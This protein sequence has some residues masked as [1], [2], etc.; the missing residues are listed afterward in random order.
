M[1]K[2]LLKSSGIRSVLI[3]DDGY[4][5][6]PRLDDL[7][8]TNADWATFFDDLTED[9]EVLLAK[10]YP[11]FDPDKADEHAKDELFLRAIWDL[12]ERLSDEA[13]RHILENYIY[14]QDAMASFL[15]DAEALFTDYGLAVERAGRNFVGLAS[16]AD[17]ILI[18]LYLGAQH[19]RD[20]LEISVAGLKTIIDKRAEKPPAIILMSSHRSIANK[21]AAFRDS[22][23]VFASGFRA[24]SKDHLREKPRREQIL[25]ELARHRADSLKLSNFLLT[26][27]RG[28]EQAISATASDLRRLDLEDI[29]QLQSLLLDD[30][31]ES[32]SSYML[33]LIDRLL[34]HE[35][36][37]VRPIITAAKALDQMDSSQHPPNTMGDT[38][39]N[40]ELIHKTLYIHPNRRILDGKDGYPVRFG[41]I[42]ALKPKAKPPRGSIFAGAPDAVFAVVTPACDLVREPPAAK[43]VLLIEGECVPVDA[44]AYDPKAQNTTIVLKRGNQKFGVRWKIKNLSTLTRTKL[45]NLLRRDEV[46]VAGRLRTE[47]A[48]Q[49]QQSVLS[50]I[51]RIG[52]MATMPTNYPIS[53]RLYVPNKERELIIL[54][55]SLKGM[56]VVGRANMKK[57][58]RIGFDSSQLHDFAEA[59]RGL[60]P[61]I[62]GHSRQVI[63]KLTEPSWLNILFADGAQ[64]DLAKAATKGAEIKLEKV[65]ADFKCGKAVYEKD[66][67]EVIADPGQ[68]QSIGLLFE[69]ADDR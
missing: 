26:W 47:F 69:I 22:V 4:D 35:V 46:N 62:H 12:R 37:A 42:I 25:L 15:V 64:I 65:A 50:G 32:R 8:A 23:G 1:I 27:Q 3:V 66:A 38:K 9:D 29:A 40:L 44:A 36:E 13:V 17:L 59:L 54:P 60:M 41:D 24:I 48:A 53:A 5:E 10:A 45:E 56:C 28:I 33:D 51:G 18:D 49:L 57:V 39:D 34:I 7:G 20:D 31:Q 63:E 21:R 61:E 14:N 58:A 11:D 30:E 52:V 6:S 16:D 68:R 2:E 67:T 19:E 55:I 43:H